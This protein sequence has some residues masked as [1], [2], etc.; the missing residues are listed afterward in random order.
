MKENFKKRYIIYLIIVIALLALPFRSDSI[1]LNMQ[2][3]EKNLGT[4]VN[5][6]YVKKGHKSDL[7]KFYHM[8]F[9]DVDDFILY[10]PA[11]TMRVNEVAVF[12]AKKGKE[13]LVLKAATDRRDFQRKVFEGYGPKQC[14]QLDNSILEKKGQYVI[15]VT[16][17]DSKDLY[18]AIEKGAK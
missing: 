13:D 3:V 2:K 18:K 14:K 11:T 5:S 16:G 10:I 1:D 8:H 4:T 17:E 6:E 12:K 15:F 7:R 9:E